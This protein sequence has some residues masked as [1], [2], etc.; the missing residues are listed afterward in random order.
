MSNSLNTAAFTWT[1]P[2]CGGVST[3]DP[4][5]GTVSVVHKDVCSTAPPAI[6]ALR[7]AAVRA[8]IKEEEQ[9]VDRHTRRANELKAQLTEWIANER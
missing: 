6:K 1:C 4:S 8:A 3:H 9:A 7:T 5:E 2:D